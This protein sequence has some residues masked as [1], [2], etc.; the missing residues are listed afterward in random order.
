M[1]RLS[2]IHICGKA[3]GG[4]PIADLSPQ[5]AQSNCQGNGQQLDQ[6]VKPAVHLHT[7]QLGS[8]I[9]LFHLFFLPYWS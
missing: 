8:K 6:H 4:N 5:R 7:P 3:L 9:H 2:L 1:K